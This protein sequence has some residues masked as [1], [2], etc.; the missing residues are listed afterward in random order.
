MLRNGREQVGGERH[1]VST[2]LESSFTV[3]SCGVHVCLCALQ[4]QEEMCQVDGSV[5]WKFAFGG[6]QL[7][8]FPANFLFTLEITLLALAPTLIDL[9]QRVRGDEASAHSFV[10]HH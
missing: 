10:W 8:D 2:C 9:F 6:Q 5:F 3:A 1:D 7:F 4:L